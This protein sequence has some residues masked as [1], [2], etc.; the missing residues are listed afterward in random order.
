MRRFL[1]VDDDLTTRTLWETSI[2][3][4]VEDVEVTAMASADLLFVDGLLEPGFESKY[5]AVVSDI[6]LAGDVTGIELM[7][8]LSPD[9]QRRSILCSGIDVPRFIEV[10]RAM[11][12]MCVFVQKP[13]SPTLMRC[14]L[15]RVIGQQIPSSQ[16]LATPVAHRGDDRPV[17]LVTGCSSGI[18]LELAQILAEVQDYRVVLTARTSSLPFMRY[19]FVETDRLVIEK[20]DLRDTN[21][22]QSAVA[23][24]IERWGRI[25]VVVNNAGVC[26]R[27][28]VEHMDAESELEQMQTN[29]LGPMALIRHVLPSMRERGRGKIINVSSVAGSLGMPTMASYGASKHAIEA[30]SEALWYEMKP[31]GINVSVIRPGFV[32]SSSFNRIVSPEKATLAGSLRGPYADFYEFMNTLI[33]WCMRRS[34]STSKSVAKHVLKVIQ[35]QNPPLWVHATFDARLFHLLKRVIPAN[36][37]HRMIDGSLRTLVPL[38]RRYSRADDRRLRA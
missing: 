33:G 13:L 22:I 27:S 17:M 20:M 3:H 18:G 16:C 30:A 10:R 21:E 1:L 7:N 2:R 4:L 12:L 35:K 24:V 5:D 32:N 9:F 14:A 29:Y 31:L 28:V 6:F 25:D 15:Q 37:F 23:N 8:A 26:Y 36:W 19:H 11:D 34:P 38:G